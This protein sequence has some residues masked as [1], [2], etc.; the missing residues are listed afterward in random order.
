LHH[1]DRKNLYRTRVQDKLS[2]KKEWPHVFADRFDLRN[3]NAKNEYRLGGYFFERQALDA[4]RRSNFPPVKN[5]DSKILPEKLASKPAK[6]AKPNDA[7]LHGY[8]LEARVKPA[9]VL[10]PVLSFNRG[11]TGFVKTR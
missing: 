5:S 10:D 2:R 8:H 7:D 9:T 4:T 3:G 6:S 11:S 1:P